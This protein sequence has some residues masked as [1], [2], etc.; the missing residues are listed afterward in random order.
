MSKQRLRSNSEQGDFS[1]CSTHET[2][3]LDP[4][5]AYVQAILTFRLL[6]AEEEADLAREIKVDERSATYAR[7]ALIEHNLRLVVHVARHYQGRGLE[8]LDLIQEGNLGLMRAVETFDPGR[9]RF[10]T[11]A[12]FWISQHISRALDTSA[13]L[14]RFPSYRLIQLRRMARLSQSFFEAL[15]VDPSTEQIATVMHLDPGTVSHLRAVGRRPISLDAPAHPDSEMRLSE[16]LPDVSLPD[17]ESA[18]I[19][20][21]EH[22]EQQ[23]TI[24]DLLSVLTEREREVIR[25]HYGLDGLHLRTLAEIGRQLGISRERARQINDAAMKKVRRVVQCTAFEEVVEQRQAS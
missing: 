24:A 19:E 11:Y 2:T 8:L 14:I 9:G 7:Q 6:S 10:S 18:F 22:C 1:P 13:R 23:R 21:E 15:G 20:L 12:V 3:P 5:S 25:L 16:T 4:V 17:Q